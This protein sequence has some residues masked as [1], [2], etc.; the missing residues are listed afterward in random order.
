MESHDTL[1]KKYN[2]VKLLGIGGF[3]RVY[4][5]TN[6]NDNN[7]YAARIRKDIKNEQSAKDDF[8]HELQITTV[9]S[10]LNNPNIIR[11]FDHGEG[12]LNI[13]TDKNIVNYMILEYCPKGDLFSY[14]HLGR[15]IEKHAKYIFKKILAG[16]Q[17]LHEAG[18]CHRSLKLE[19]ILLDQNFNL[20][21]NNFIFATQFQQNDQ[22]IILK[23]SVGNLHYSSPQ[24]LVNQPYNGEKNDI[25]SLGIILFNLV[26]GK[27]GFSK[28]HI[29]DPYY[30][31]ILS[32][33]INKYWASLPNEITNIN[34]SNEF[35]DLY[36]NMINFN[37]DKRPNISQ[38][39][40]HHW[41]DEINN[42]D[43]EQ[44]KQLELEVKN[45][46]TKRWDQ[47]NQNL[48]DIN[49]NNKNSDI[50]IFKL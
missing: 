38:I 13:G 35:K 11:L 19:N 17:V 2:I 33:K 37:E 39:M 23:E 41:F 22:P 18:Y 9:I 3:S 28:A 6:I 40:N 42:L 20:K 14:I 44:L 15:L 47:F 29:N 12:E 1:D 43:N 34:Y 10:G 8:E 21:I 24:I 50:K 45:E 16:V 5:V 26:T 32:E 4:L 7:Q 31:Y 36:I 27:F 49:N 48:N 46:F 30:K 25:F